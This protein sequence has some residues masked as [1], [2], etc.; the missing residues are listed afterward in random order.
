MSEKVKTPFLRPN[1]QNQGEV[2]PE[3]ELCVSP[4][5]WCAGIHPVA[6][7]QN[8]LATDESYAKL[9]SEPLVENKKNYFYVRCKNGSDETVSQLQV[10]LY[11]TRASIICWP[12][13]WVEIGIDT[14]QSSTTNTIEAVEAGAIGV[15]KAPFVWDFHSQPACDDN[16]CFIAQLFSD[17]YPNP[18]PSVQ[19]P[20]YI[21]AMLE[22]N[23]L[24]AEQNIRTMECNPDVPKTSFDFALPI[25]ADATPKTNDYL[26]IVRMSGLST[27]WQFL[28]Q[29]SRTDSNGKEI[30]AQIG[31]LQALN[32]VGNYTFVPGFYSQITVSLFNKTGELPPAGSFVQVEVYNKILPTEVALAKELCAYNHKRIENLRS[33]CAEENNNDFHPI[34]I[35]SYTV[36]FK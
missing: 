31:D 19:H 3:G 15:V 26:L 6:D 16:Y 12:G 17:K 8:T 14:A 35:G 27:P 5:I 11:Y 10:K 25:P 30:G 23:L 22:K 9:S 29:S 20:I 13:D 24:W 2:P 32:M 18:L 28:V 36:L 4:D 34:L 1:L 33:V 21:A 7:F